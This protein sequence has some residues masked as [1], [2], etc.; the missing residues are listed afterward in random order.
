MVTASDAEQPRSIEFL[1]PST[2]LVEW[3]DGH[4]SIYSHRY[5]REQCECAACID[6]WT[7]APILDPKTLPA[8]VHVVRVEKTGRYG[9]NLHFSDGH[10]TGIYSFRSLR[11]NCPCP[12]CVVE[13][14]AP[15]SPEENPR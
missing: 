7:R 4:E 6:E 11:R 1:E 13:S 14:P 10:G 8:D 12:E 3:G 5:L 2:L 9:L 15:D